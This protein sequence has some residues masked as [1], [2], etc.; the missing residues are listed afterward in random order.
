M[1]YFCKKLL[2]NMKYFPPKVSPVINVNWSPLYV[3]WGTKQNGGGAKNNWN[4]RGRGNLLRLTIPPLL[5][6]FSRFLLCLY[7]S[8]ARYGG[9]ANLRYS[10]T[11]P[12]FLSQHYSPT[13]FDKS[14][15]SQEVEKHQVEFTFWDTSGKK[16]VLNAFVVF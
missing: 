5:F 1:K 8:R 14:F 9:S 13:S 16:G 4:K 6:V 3:V 15:A 11:I 2:P 10:N 12:S 7:F